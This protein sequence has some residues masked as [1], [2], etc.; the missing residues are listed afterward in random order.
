M[1]LRRTGA[2]ALAATVVALAAPASAFAH[3]Y[4][5]RTSPSASVTVNHPPKEVDLTYDEA[6]EPRFATVSV[7]N[8]DAAAGGDGAAAALADERR[9]ARHA[10]S[11]R[12]CPQGWYL[13]YWRAISADGHPVQGRVHVRGRPEPRPGA[14]V[15]DPLADGERGHARP[16]RRALGRCSSPSCARSDCFCCGRSIARRRAA[17]RAGRVGAVRLD[18]VLRLDRGRADRDADLRR[19]VDRQ[20]R[21][22]GRISTSGR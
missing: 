12:T 16:A 20:V 2:A 15:R 9:H 11:S 8:P 19:D 22:G 6:V 3:A 13:V 17:S 10:R 1:R 7:T 14:A 18:R 4:L 21:A 5:I